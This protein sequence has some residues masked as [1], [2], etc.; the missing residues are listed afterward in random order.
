MEYIDVLGRRIAY[1]TE[2]QGPCLLLVH[3][4]GSSYE[5]WGRS[6]GELSKYFTVF[7]V[8]LPGHGRSG[9]LQAEETSFSFGVVFLR[10][11]C[12]EL[13]LDRPI[14]AGFSFGGLLALR[15]TLSYPERV[16]KLILVSSAG[17]GRHISWF[18][19]CATLPGL[20]ELLTVPSRLKIRML[21]RDHSALSKDEIAALYEA[22]RLPGD[23]DVFL[24]MLRYG[25]SFWGGQKE[26][27]QVSDGSLKSLEVP[28]LIIWGEQDS[29]FPLADGA[30]AASVLPNGE[31]HAF[32]GAGHWP[33]AEH[34]EEFA[35]VVRD[36]CFNGRVCPRS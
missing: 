3:G 24:R 22:R 16:E 23:Q 25:V 21:A 31:F 13:G 11:L 34:P 15:Y 4:L 14:V 19:R 7:A 35:R 32:F 10:E 12:D 20:G 33:Q 1:E 5:E 8:D 9:P 2:G 29:R 17:L 6:F 36:F 28:T 30:R 27:V 18:I 26:T